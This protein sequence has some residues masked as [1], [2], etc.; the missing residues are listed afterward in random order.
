MKNKIKAIALFSLLG[1]LIPVGF[2]FAEELD[3][4]EVSGAGTSAVNQVYTVQGTNNGHNWYQSDD[5]TYYI[6]SWS[7]DNTKWFMGAEATLVPN[8]NLYRANIADITGTW[9]HSGGD[10]GSDPSPTVSA[11]TTPPGCST[12]PET[13]TSTAISVDKAPEYYF[14]GFLL[15]FIGFVIMRSL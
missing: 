14:Y 13:P 9:S 7:G 5:T 4:Y 8:T 15:F 1:T 2:V 6:Y 12:T 11:T 3:C 10:T